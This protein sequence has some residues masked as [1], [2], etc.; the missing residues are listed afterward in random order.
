MAQMGEKDVNLNELIFIH[1]GF[2]L[3][4]ANLNIDAQ[5]ADGIRLHLV[6]YLSSRHHV[7]A[8]VKGG[9]IQIDKLP[10][11]SDVI[12]DIMKTV[13]LKIGH[14]EINYGDGHFRRTDNGNAMYNPF[15]GNYIMDAFDTQI[16]AEAYFQK[17]G[18]I[19]MAGI[20]A[21]EIR[22]DITSGA[23]DTDDPVVNDA[24]DL[25]FFSS[26]KGENSPAVYGKLDSIQKLMIWFVSG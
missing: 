4:T 20:T 3:A 7:E 2:N 5:L 22:G 15:V 25:G 16:G 18:V 11:N 24:S 17:S 14:M 19:A 23:P 10:F 6:T 12:D 26:F 9:Y 13:T 8:W 21:G 1:S